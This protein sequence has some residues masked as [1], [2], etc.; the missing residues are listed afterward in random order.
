MMLTLLLLIAAISP[1]EP[2]DESAAIAA[3]KQ[4]ITK[5]NGASESAQMELLR[6]LRQDL[7][8]AEVS[9]Q[10]AV[11]AGTGSKKI[12][13]LN[14]L[15][16]GMNDLRTEINESSVESD[17][18]KLGFAFS[19]VTTDDGAM[20]VLKNQQEVVCEKTYDGMYVSYVVLFT[21]KDIAHLKSGG[22]V[23]FTFR[24]SAIRMFKEG[25]EMR[26]VVAAV[27]PGGKKSK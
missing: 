27:A 17:F 23:N 8:G 16:W 13:H 25:V 18:Q 10:S 2:M 19:G 4:A 12:A 1:Q 14:W 7:F 5:A 22:K 11:I 9:V 3:V 24:V 21:T 15:V 26:G 6:K 20:R